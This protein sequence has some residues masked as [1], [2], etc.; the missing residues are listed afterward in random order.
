MKEFCSVSPLQTFISL[1]LALPVVMQAWTYWQRNQIKL[2]LGLD[3]KEVQWKVIFGVMNIFGNEGKYGLSQVLFYSN[4]TSNSTG[5]RDSPQTMSKSCSDKLALKSSTSLLNSLLANIID[6]SSCYL[7]FL[8]VPQSA[9]HQAGFHRA[10]EERLKPIRGVVWPGG[11]SVH[12]IR[13]LST[14]LSIPPTLLPHVSSD[15][16]EFGATASSSVI[17][18]VGR[19]N[20]AILGGI[21]MGSAFP[22]SVRGASSLCRARM[23]QDF[24]DFISRGSTRL[25]FLELLPKCTYAEIKRKAGNRTEPVKR[26]VREAFGGWETNETDSEFTIVAH[27]LTVE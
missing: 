27:H 10:F 21:K 25:L 4:S 20:E 15:V 7:D 1:F 12:P 18:V 14:T 5:R 9:F 16:N 3:L 26:S 11:F 17:Y 22:P 23:A 6:P 13:A 2:L 19:P 24:F 8:V